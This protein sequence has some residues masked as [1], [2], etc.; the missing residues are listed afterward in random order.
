MPRSSLTTFGFSLL[1]AAA[2]IARA[3]ATCAVAAC[4]A[5]ASMPRVHAAPDKKSGPASAAKSGEAAKGETKPAAATKP[6]TAEKVKATSKVTGT[7]NSAAAVR[8]EWKPFFHKGRSYVG[9]EAVAAYYGFADYN[10]NGKNVTLSMR[11]PPIQIECTVGEKRVRLNKMVFY[12]SFP[13]ISMYDGSKIL[14]SS[15]DVSNLLDPILRPGARRDPAMLKVVVLDPAGGGVEPGIISEWGRE[16]DISLDIAR[17]MKP[18]LEQA[19][20]TVVMIRDEDVAVFPLERIRLANLIHEESVYVSIRVNT[21]SQVTARGFECA[22]L[23]PA[24]TPATFE[25]EVED[26]D[27]RFFPGNI[28]DRESMALA[29]TI[30]RHVL[31]AAKANDLGI[32]RMHFEELRGIEMPAVVCRAGFLSH[33]EEGKQLTTGAYRESL[34][35]GMVSG[36]L[37]YGEFLRKGMEER[38]AEDQARPLFFGRAQATHLDSSAGVQGERII[39]RVPIS[40]AS[41]VGIDRSKMEVQLFV[42]ERVNLLDIDLTVANP[43][44]VE[45]LSVLP[46]WSDVRTET[47]QA[48]FERPPLNTAELRLYGRRSYY[49]Y[50]ARLVYNG[51]L[52]D[53][54][55]EPQNLDR[56]LYYFTPVFPRR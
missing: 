53:E 13:V 14:I 15:F 55:A 46:D 27:K 45:W 12:L 26:I 3:A 30:Q 47:F 11:D 35:R 39:V 56:C 1:H 21:S 10:R 36:I 33:K 51:R 18:M 19:G 17:R 4:L 44:K 16:K 2:Q 49:G 43:P 37:R 52:L 32:K 22:T 41:G 40:T 20:L 29:T 34:A 23:P 7:A 9:L 31:A 25:P 28:N 6:T 38:L 42:F 54:I 8:A 48:I 24:S 5:A 50:V